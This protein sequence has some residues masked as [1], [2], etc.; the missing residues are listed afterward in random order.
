MKTENG[1]TKEMKEQLERLADR[2]DQISDEVYD[3]GKEDG[4]GGILNL[5]DV[6]SEK[7]EQFLNHKE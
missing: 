1:M 4:T 3:D 5:C 7:I 6:L 2:L